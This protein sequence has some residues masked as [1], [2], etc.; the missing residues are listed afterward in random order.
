M[1]GRLL[2][3][4]LVLGLIAV[5]AEGAV[6][7][8][9]PLAAQ[10]AVPSTP[11]PS[12]TSPVVA[13]TAP[14]GSALSSAV[15]TSRL[16]PLLT[17][18]SKIGPRSGGYVV[19]PATSSVLFSQKSAEG[20]IPASVT[21]VVTAAVALSVIGAD[22]LYV[23]GKKG[24]A[25]SLTIVPTLTPLSSGASAATARSIAD[26]TEEMLKHSD[27]GLAQALANESVR[28][29]GSSWQSLVS[30]TLLARGIDP[31]GVVLRDGS[32]I[33]RLNRLSPAVVGA[34]LTSV[35]RAGSADPAWGL[36]TG[37]PVAGWDGTLT[38]RFSTSSS[39]AGQGLV[40]AKTGTLTGVISLAGLTPTANGDLL[41]FVFMAD[42]VA[43]NYSGQVRTRNVFDAAASVLTQC[44]C[45]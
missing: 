42:R 22:E 16:R 2:P 25:A 23:V 29:S 3:A 17:S 39:T 18:Y 35:I 27:N 13:S 28:V 15:V 37:L 20:F 24:R 19:D 32:G 30:A 12:S 1:R 31:T 41:V 8:F 26:I 38:S 4:A 44:G 21:K 6:F 43:P 10:A 11:V 33:S 45:R 14:T 36:L 34:L 7:G 5:T 40:R 9:G